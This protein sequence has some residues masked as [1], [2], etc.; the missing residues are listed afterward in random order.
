MKYTIATVLLAVF[1]T[2]KT[3]DELVEAIPTCAVTCIRDAAQTVNCDV[4]DFKCSC[5]KV[6]ELTPSVV[7]CL[8]KSSC[9]ADEQTNVLLTAQQIC[10]Q[11]ASGDTATGGV[12]AAAAT[13]TSNEAVVTSSAGAAAAT[14]SSPGAAGRVQAAGWAGAIAAVAA[15]AL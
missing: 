15:L 13:P 11:V 14:T 12:T 2:A 4:A 3:I 1:A 6:N 8:S 5:G 10:V 7:S 9:T